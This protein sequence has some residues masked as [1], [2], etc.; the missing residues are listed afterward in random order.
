[1]KEN[2][3][4]NE[5]GNACLADLGLLTIASDATDVASSNTFQDKR[6]SRWRSPELLHPMEFD[7]KEVRPTTSSD[8]YLLGMVI[9]YGVSSGR[10]PFFNRKGLGVVVKVL[11]DAILTKP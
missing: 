5:S 1:M 6:T 4:I 9:L 8:C 2:I 11:E 3:I 7:L 10:I